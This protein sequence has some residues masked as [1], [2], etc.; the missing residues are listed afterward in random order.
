MQKRG[1]FRGRPFAF[2]ITTLDESAPMMD[3]N[4]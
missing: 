3:W 2:M 4:E 1:A